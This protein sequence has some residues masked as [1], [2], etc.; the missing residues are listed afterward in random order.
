MEGY[1]LKQ[2]QAVIFDMDGTL[3]DS[4]RMVVD[5]LTAF[6]EENGLGVT[7]ELLKLGFGCTS[8]TFMEAIGM[9]DPPASSRRWRE[10]MRSMLDKVVLFDGVAEVL[11][12]PIR[13]G[14]V[15]S[16]VRP[17]LE[18]NIERHQLNGFFEVMVTAD[19]T[20]YQKPHPRPLL[21]CLEKMQLSPEAALF[22]GDS[23]YDYECALAAGVDFGL[24]SWGADDSALF[25][26]ATYLFAHPTDILP[27]VAG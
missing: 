17:E 20:P 24:A 26:K 12:A 7:D 14:V 2:Y 23:N 13:R 16:Q 3:L 9:P 6:A 21:Y 25:P 11:A 5:S 4:H 18:I 22:V 15:T 19:S 27:L 10:I 8:D 1:S